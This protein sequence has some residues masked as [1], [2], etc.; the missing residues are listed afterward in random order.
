MVS[1]IWDERAYQCRRISNYDIDYSYEFT[2]IPVKITAH[3]L[4]HTNYVQIYKD[5]N[6]NKKTPN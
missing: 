5:V 1:S 4:L 3:F 6:E 2:F